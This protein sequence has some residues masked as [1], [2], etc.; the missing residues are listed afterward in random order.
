MPT[1]QRRR[2]PP[3]R[4]AAGRPPKFT[5]EQMIAALQEKRGGVYLAAAMLGCAANTIYERAKVSAA[6]ADCIKSEDGKVDDVA[7]TVVYQSLLSDDKNLA[8]RAA[9]YRLS[10]K[11]K[12]RGYTEKSELEVTGDQ[13]EDMTDDE[14]AA[15]VERLDKLRSSSANSGSAPG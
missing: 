2:R 6:V 13:F 5:D 8:L 4:P 12:H 15:E 11:G 14:L 7:E 3:R 10:T 9:M 1:T